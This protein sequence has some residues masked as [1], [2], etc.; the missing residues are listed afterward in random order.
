MVTGSISS[1][2]FPPRIPVRRQKKRHLALRYAPIAMFREQPESCSPFGEPYRPPSP[3]VLGF[4]D[5]ELR[6]H[7]AGRSPDPVLMNGPGDVADLTNDDMT[8]YG[9]PRSALRPGCG[10]RNMGARASRRTW[11]GAVGLR[12]H[13]RTRRVPKG[14]L[15]EPLVP[16]RLQ[17]LEQSAR[18][19]WEMIQLTRDVSGVPRALLTDPVSVTFSQHGGSGTSMG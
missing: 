1:P 10:I 12:A 18:G 13:C 19:D 8:V 14:W 11:S 2:K 6:E 16:V 17:R 4:S 15:C 9:F 5:V 3:S 7:M